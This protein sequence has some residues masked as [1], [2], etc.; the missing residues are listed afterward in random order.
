MFLF[1]VG[2]RLLLDRD[3]SFL[4][5]SNKTIKKN[6]DNSQDLSA[7][8]TY[9]NIESLAPAVTGKRL[10]SKVNIFVSDLS[11]LSKIR[12]YLLYTNTLSNER[13]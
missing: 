4:N 1:L 2:K 7:S 11:P 8:E 10:V 9:K 3:F 13:F 12:S 6:A 5:Y